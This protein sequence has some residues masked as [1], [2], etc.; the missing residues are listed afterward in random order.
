MK[1][2][3][4]L[5]EPK[6]HNYPAAAS[7]LTLS[8]DPKQ[9]TTAVEALK[10]APA[11]TFKAKDIVRASGLR[12]LDESNSH[13]HDNLKKIEDGTE[14]S[15]VLLV[16]DTVLGKVVIADGYH[17]VSATQLHDEDADIPVRIVSIR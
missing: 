16:R 12:M 7:F 17:R 1:T 5:A 14:M 3:K 9:V 15:P 8:Y 6:P 2:V 10:H 11:V 4:W 13:V